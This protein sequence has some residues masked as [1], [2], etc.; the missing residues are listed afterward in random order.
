[1]IAWYKRICKFYQFDV[2]VLL[3]CEI[4]THDTTINSD[5]IL[6]NF[7]WPYLGNGLSDPLH[8]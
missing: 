3:N 8:L 7:E 4:K 5:A 2:G 6:E 1:M